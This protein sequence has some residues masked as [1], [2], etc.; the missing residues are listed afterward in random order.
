MQNLQDCLAQNNRRGEED[1][2]GHS[3]DPGGRTLDS[4]DESLRPPRQAQPFAGPRRSEEN[5]TASGNLRSTDI[6][7]PQSQPLLVRDSPYDASRAQEHPGVFQ[8]P[9]SSNDYDEYPSPVT[10]MGAAVSLTGNAQPSPGGFYG[11]SSVVALV[12]AIHP[13]TASAN[14]ARQDRQ[15]R[16]QS[17]S[18]IAPSWT[19][20]ATRKDRFLE[21]AYSLPPRNVA[22]KLL[23]LYF[24]NVHIFYPWIHAATFMS[25]F[26]RIWAGVDLYDSDDS[27]VDVG[28]GGAR[29]SSSAFHCALNALFALGCEFSDAPADEKDETSNIFYE[30][31]KVL[32]PVDILDSG[33]LGD[34]QTLLL[35]SQYMLCTQ[36]PTR[37]WNAVGLACRMA[38]GLGLQFEPGADLADLEVEMRRR[39]WYGCLQMDM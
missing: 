17:A 5:A 8:A 15:R 11:Q 29:C 31:M 1:S 22:D 24:Q 25:R 35:V 33:D 7:H 9:Q 12:N 6:L 30:R 2:A 18:K 34:I 13:T 19:N 23:E 28:I 36:N 26:K 20:R 39:V 10:A 32:L 14:R 37:C 21:A 4:R 27:T 16:P 38:V 3:R